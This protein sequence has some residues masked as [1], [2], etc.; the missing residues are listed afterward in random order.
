MKQNR[1]NTSKKKKFEDAILW[2]EKCFHNCLR[3]FFILK[4]NTSNKKQ[5]A[6]SRIE[7]YLSSQ[8]IQ[9]SS[10]RFGD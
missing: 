3:L 1:T 6:Y 10:P 2:L 4:T 7:A 5:K 9:S 8:K